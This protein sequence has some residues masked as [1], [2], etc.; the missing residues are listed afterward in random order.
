MEREKMKNEYEIRGNIV[1]IFLRRKDG[2]RLETVID[3]RD[4][5]R[6]NELLGRWC[7]AYEK[8][9]KSFYVK[10]A[11]GIYLHRWLLNAPKEMLVDH[12]N[13]DTLNNLRNNLQ[14]CTASEN[15]QNRKNVQANNSSG[16]LGVFWHNGHKRWRVETYHN[17]KPQ[18]HGEFKNLNDAVKRSKEIRQIAMPHSFENLLMLKENLQQ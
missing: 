13:H 8:H 11:C 6:A 7:A 14:I 4:F 15:G 1:A 9:T 18:F 12:I 16:Y 2:T 5:A 3:L 17:G 10:S